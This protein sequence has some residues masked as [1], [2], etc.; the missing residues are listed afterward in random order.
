MKG[1]VYLGVFICM[2]QATE[3]CANSLVKGR[4]PLKQPIGQHSYAVPDSLPDTNNNRLKLLSFNT[5]SQ[6]ISPAVSN[7]YLYFF[8]SNDELDTHIF[9]VKLS[10]VSFFDKKKLEE[11]IVK[12]LDN[13][14]YFYLN[15]TT[16]G[17]EALLN[18]IDR[19]IGTNNLYIGKAEDLDNFSRLQ[20]FAYNSKKFSNGRATISPDGKMMVFS[21]DRPGSFGKVDLWLCKFDRGKWQVP[22]NIGKPINT[23]GNETMPCFISNTRLCF[24]SDEHTGFGGF[25][26]FYT[27]LKGGRF[28]APKNMGSEINSKYNDFG[29]CYSKEN[30]C[31]Y[32]SSD[33]RGNYDI[34]SCNP[35]TIGD[36]QRQFND[37]ALVRVEAESNDKPKPI[38][39]PVA[40]SVKKVSAE[41]SKNISSEKKP[42]IATV[43]ANAFTENK[44]E[45][46]DTEQAQSDVTE[47]VDERIKTTAVSPRAKDDTEPM[48]RNS[49]NEHSFYSIQLA[50]LG[51]ERFNKGYYRKKLDPR[52]KYY[53]VR[54]DGLIKIRIGHFTSYRQAALY[55]KENR[56]GE[57]YIVRMNSGQVI[58]Y[59]NQD[60]N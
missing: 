33:R 11:I 15:Y 10:D 52:K 29:I 19:K 31:Y 25:D 55:V 16:D 23:K 40:P 57:F 3:I 50:A 9:R 47:P 35:E 8:E 28:T 1:F 53:L 45:F 49:S 14:I 58:E 22:E 18:V 12:P 34:Y 48:V 54:E 60:S 20:P 17:S 41:S 2:F 46:E 5:V 13:Y 32:F 43:P 37:Q 7:G 42:E 36:D 24:A 56:I 21:S 38:G 26:L 30:E 44:T 39:N 27:D 59:L 4:G 51:A 6:E